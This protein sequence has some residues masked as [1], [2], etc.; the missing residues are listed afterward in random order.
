MLK[1]SLYEE[2]FVVWTTHNAELLR[3]G[4]LQGAD[5]EHIAE[6][7]E[8]MGKSQRRALESRLTVLLLYLLKWQFQ[9][10]RRSSSWRAPIVAQRIAIAKILREAPSLESHFSKVSGEAYRDAVELAVAETEFPADRFPSYVPYALDQLLN[11]GFFPGQA[12]A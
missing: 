6:E 4:R 7:L 5:I 11:R 2:D 12:G 10:E 1:P 8:D 3:A 9:P